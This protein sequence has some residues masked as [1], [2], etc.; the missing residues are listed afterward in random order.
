MFGDYF[1][2]K[3]IKKKILL[4][5][6]G[7]YKNLEEKILRKKQI[8]FYVKFTIIFC[9]LVF[10]MRN[11]LILF[12]KKEIN[13]DNSIKYEKEDNIDFSKYS[14]TI[15]PIAF[16]N[17]N[18]NLINE[19]IINNNEIPKGNDNIIK[20]LEAH[21][22]LAKNH[23]IYGFGI[24][25]FWSPNK[26]H[27]NKI[28]DI[29]LQNKNSEI[30]FLLVLERDKEEV[31]HA[32]INITQFFLEIKN[33]IIDERYIKFDNKPVIGINQ[34]ECNNKNI[35]LLRE[36][37]KDYGLGDIYILIRN[38]SNTPI[39][40]KKTEFD[41]EVYSPTHQSLEKVIFYYNNTFGYF[42]THL[43]YHNLLDN[44]Y[45]K[46]SNIF[47]TSVA[48]AKYP[49]YVKENKSYI[50]GDYTPEKFYF[51]NK[52]VAD[53]TLKN[54]NKDN[55]Y[56][57]IDEYNNLKQDD[58]LGYANINYF[59]KALFGLPLT[60]NRNFNLENLKKSVLVLVQVHVFYTDLLPEVINKTNN[61]PVPF[62]LYITTNT[63]EKKD[64]II[65][66]IKDNT[67]ANIYEI[68]ITPNKGRDV[69][70]CLIQIK[71]IFN[72]YKYFCHV[73]TKKH[74]ETDELGNHWKT[75]LYENL[76]GNEN[77][78]SQILSDFENHKDLGLVF[79]EHFYVQIKYAYGV[80][81]IN[82]KYINYIF[83]ILFPDKSIKAGD[84]RTFPVGNMFWARTE[85]IYQIF[86]QEIFKRVPEER[87]QIDGTILHG[88]ERFWPF[89]AK[90]NGFYYKT[91]LFYI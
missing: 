36:K 71:D 4:E 54:K 52:I 70:P 21:F 87:G 77:I 79:P 80:N 57:F 33:I 84:I 45:D 7:N 59:S 5:R 16:Y 44:S 38:N 48:I 74:G 66:Y 29:I 89:L 53:W 46:R 61:I 9:S 19:T 86:N 37:F 3:A 62:D 17:A 88:I 32:D 39:I 65:N 67:K 63:Q 13:I 24:F 12:L 30:Q 85:A 75:Y 91:L 81:P 26:K 20:Q 83:Q 1:G 51:L 43:L 11:F 82:W 6:T 78:I 42:Y 76:L 73:H 2:E 15:K 49:L 64:F 8:L 22:N 31:N 28:F 14:T 58:I 55:Q 60:F 18:I 10:F 47:R 27:I 40:Q 34:E 25:Y 41:G 72:K 35:E 50:Y 56:I 23:G 69:I 90:L 68:L